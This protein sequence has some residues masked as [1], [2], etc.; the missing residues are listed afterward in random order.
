[1]KNEGDP[2]REHQTAKPFG[3]RETGGGLVFHR[4]WGPL[5]KIF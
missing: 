5:V 3:E 4:R 1:M 2:V